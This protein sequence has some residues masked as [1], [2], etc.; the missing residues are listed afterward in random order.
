MISSTNTISPQSEVI[1]L[2]PDPLTSNV[3]K[4]KLDSGSPPM[5]KR[6]RIEN[7]PP[8]GSH[9]PPTSH[10]KY[11]YGNYDRYY[12]Y[13][14]PN[15]IKDVRVEALT[16]QPHLFYDA[17]VLDIGCNTG[18]LTIAVARELRVRSIIGIDIDKSLIN[19]ARQYISVEIKAQ[20]NSSNDCITSTYPHNVL[21][22]TANYILSD[23]KLLELEQPQFDTILCMSITKWL[24]LN[25][26]DVGLK[27]AFQRMYRQLRPGGRLILEAQ[28]WQS[29]KRRKKLTDEIFANF[30]AIK[31]MPNKFEE[32]LLSGEVG[33]AHSYVLEIPAHVAH[34]FRRPIKV[35]FHS[36][37]LR[38][39][40]NNSVVVSFQVFEKAKE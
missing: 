26:G 15:A 5:S 40:M 14:N 17:D 30:K 27:L 36:Y 28:D 18:I 23:A 38:D 33:F 11:Q 7:K 10:P 2:P 4:R 12:G 32:Y 29:Y 35:G 6:P 8:C 21:F 39:V 13:R 9:K 20:S 22:K 25:N 34:G 24:H 19:R 37:N 31:L 16:R 3:L 1:L